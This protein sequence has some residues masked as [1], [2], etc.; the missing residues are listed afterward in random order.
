M[1][2][3]ETPNREIQP[4]QTELERVRSELLAL[5]ADLHIPETDAMEQLRVQMRTAPGEE[6]TDLFSAY[7]DLCD[8]I[9][10]AIPSSEPDKICSARIGSI[11]LN[12]LLYLEIFED[13]EYYAL[14]QQALDSAASTYHLSGEIIDRIRKP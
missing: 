3:Q 1:L 2:N 4:S 5:A 7:Q 9:A 14:R 8:A 12:A 10:N 11:L 13:E 6:L